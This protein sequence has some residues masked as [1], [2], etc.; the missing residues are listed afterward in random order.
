MDSLFDTNEEIA[1]INEENRATYSMLSKEL[2]DICNEVCKKRYKCLEE[3]IKNRSTF[4]HEQFEKIALS[5]I[6]KYIP[7]EK[8]L[9]KGCNILLGLV[10]LKFVFSTKHKYYYLQVLV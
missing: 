10:Q 9:L 3:F 7:E 8:N 2:L 5:Y 1:R 6:T 4:T